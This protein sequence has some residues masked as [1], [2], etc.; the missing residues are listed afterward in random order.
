MVCGNLRENMRSELYGQISKENTLITNSFRF[1]ALIYASIL[2]TSKCGY[3]KYSISDLTAPRNLA[4]SRVHVAL[5]GFT[6]GWTLL[7]EAAVVPAF[8]LL[9]WH[10]VSDHNRAE[11][12]VLPHND[13]SCF[14]FGCYQGVSSSTRGSGFLKFI[15]FTG[16]QDGD[17][18]I[19]YYKQRNLEN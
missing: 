14:A 15:V 17:S 2:G 18:S 13:I 5:L 7:P 9:C 1:T 3:C 4:G 8:C 12:L 6:E 19:M 11:P 16:L 10:A